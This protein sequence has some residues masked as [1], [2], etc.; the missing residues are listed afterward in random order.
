MTAENESLRSGE[1]LAPGPP[2][3]C[4]RHDGI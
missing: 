2:G 1:E 4:R 3:G